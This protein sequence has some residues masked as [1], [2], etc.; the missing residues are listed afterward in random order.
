MMMVMIIIIVIVIIIMNNNTYIY[1]IP[2]LHYRGL[3]VEV[4][5]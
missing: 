4:P 5:L 1:T 3:G 2:L